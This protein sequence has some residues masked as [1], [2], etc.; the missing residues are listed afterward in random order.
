MDHFCPIGPCIV[1]KDEIPDPHNL[2]IR[3]WV[4]GQPKQDG[5]TANMI[6]KVDKLIEHLSG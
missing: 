6:F 3:T 2:R 4:N 1:T 5:N